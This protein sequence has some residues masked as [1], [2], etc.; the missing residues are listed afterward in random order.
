MILAFY[1]IR[2]VHTPILKDY[3]NV[4]ITSDIRATVMSVQS[5]VQKL[6]YASLGPL[7]GVVMDAYSLQV[8]LLFSGLIYGLLGLFALINM[9]RLRQI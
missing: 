3:L 4:L 1:F 7:I 6:L 8:A 5:L 2:G 9:R